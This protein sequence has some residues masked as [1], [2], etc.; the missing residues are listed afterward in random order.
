MNDQQ[1]AKHVLD[2][3]LA[4]MEVHQS[5]HR[6]AQLLLGMLVQNDK[7]PLIAQMLAKHFQ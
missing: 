2:K 6:I 4:P 7:A 1:S 5:V 3:S